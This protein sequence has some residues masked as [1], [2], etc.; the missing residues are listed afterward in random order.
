MTILNLVL[1]TIA[2]LTHIS[3]HQG[4]GYSFSNQRPFPK[5]VDFQGHC[6]LTGFFFFWK[7]WIIYWGLKQLFGEDACFK[8][9]TA[10]VAGENV[11]HYSA[12]QWFMACLTDLCQ[13]FQRISLTGAGEQCGSFLPYADERI[14]YKSGLETWCGLRF[15]LSFP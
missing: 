5:S 10:D 11:R 12:A 9:Y 13:S 4:L 1:S 2:V 15:I 3:R 6:P 8:S 7:Q 14:Q